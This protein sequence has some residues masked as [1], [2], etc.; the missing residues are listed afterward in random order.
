VS[1][2]TAAFRPSGNSIFSRQVAESSPDQTSNR[3]I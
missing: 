3:S 2:I 1:S